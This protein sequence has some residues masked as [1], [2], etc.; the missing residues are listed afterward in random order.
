LQLVC[1]CISL[2]TIGLPYAVERDKL[3]K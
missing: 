1:A 3:G 2:D